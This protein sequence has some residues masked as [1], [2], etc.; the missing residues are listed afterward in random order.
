ME[1]PSRHEKCKTR[2]TPRFLVGHHRPA[3]ELKRGERGQSG[4]VGNDQRR[5]IAGVDLL[6]RQC[7][8][9][10][11]DFHACPAER[12]DQ[13]DVGIVDVVL[14]AERAVGENELCRRSVDDGDNVP[15]LQL[16]P[17]AASRFT[18]RATLSRLE[19]V[20]SGAVGALE[21]SKATR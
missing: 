5:D 21:M 17:P 1:A 10:D 16:Y 8:G 6:S 13:R 20:L 15:V 4:Q 14:G 12:F 3:L 7:L 19:L 18:K 2:P 11:V 9:T